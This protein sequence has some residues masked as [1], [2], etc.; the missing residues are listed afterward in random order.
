MRA[1]ALHSAFEELLNQ[2]LDCEREW[3]LLD[4]IDLDIRLRALRRLDEPDAEA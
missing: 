1:A 4:R 2:V 3:R